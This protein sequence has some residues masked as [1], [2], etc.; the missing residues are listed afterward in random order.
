MG[1]SNLHLITDHKP[2]EKFLENEDVKEEENRR[3][4]N[5]RRKCENYNFCI[6]YKSGALNTADP[7]S[8]GEIPDIGTLHPANIES[9]D[10]YKKVATILR[11]FA[12][13]SK[14]NQ[15]DFERD[16]AKE[17]E[18]WSEEAR[19]SISRIYSSEDKKEYWLEDCSCNCTATCSYSYTDDDEELKKTCKCRTTRCGTA[20]RVENNKGDHTAEVKSARLGSQITLSEIGAET[21]ED[22]PLSFLRSLIVE[23]RL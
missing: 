14:E 16:I 23:G 15:T 13:H 2:L 7:L 18:Q 3:L 22:G 21:D 17:D 9:G 6:T 5:L 20:N 11:L 10:K 1:H 4:M 12:T 8:R 19:A